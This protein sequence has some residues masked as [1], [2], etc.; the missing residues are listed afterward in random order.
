MGFLVT[1]YEQSCRLKN[2]RR[3]VFLEYQSCV[4]LTL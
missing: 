4:W 2:V 1:D 3:L